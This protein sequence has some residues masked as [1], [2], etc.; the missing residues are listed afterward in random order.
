MKQMA[1]ARLSAAAVSLTA[2]S[3]GARFVLAVLSLVAGVWL[4]FLTPVGAVAAYS[5]AAGKPEPAPNEN[6]GEHR[7]ENW[8]CDLPATTTIRYTSGEELYYCDRHAASAPKQKSLGLRKILAAPFGLVA[9]LLFVIGFLG[10]L[11]SPLP[12]FGRRLEVNDAW[13]SLI[14]AIVAIP[15]TWAGALLYAALILLAR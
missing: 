10:P 2:L 7:C 11:V 8:G 13:G 15:A 9:L 6:G 12:L 14:I 3:R 5:W 1:L 4:V